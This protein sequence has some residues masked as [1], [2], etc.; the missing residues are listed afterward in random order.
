MSVGIILIKRSELGLFAWGVFHDGL[1]QVTPL[2]FGMV[3][4]FLGF[5]ILAFSV[6]VFK[7]NVGIGTFANIAFVGPMLDI[8]DFSFSYIPETMTMRI[9]LFVVGI[10]L[11]TFGRAYYISTRLGAGPRDGLF[12]GISRTTQVD[13]K[14]VKPGIELVVLLS[15][16]LLGGV[17]G[18]GTLITMVVSGYLVQWF[19]KLLGYDPKVEKQRSILEYRIVQ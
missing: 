15:G 11:M 5:I 16:F 10:L 12:V 7:T 9:V 19:F 13:V 3:T 18:V 8:I 6:L 2:S 17:A 1:S 14:Y 4:I